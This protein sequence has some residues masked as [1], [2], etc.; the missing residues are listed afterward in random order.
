MIDVYAVHT[1]AKCSWIRRLY[2]NTN[3]KWKITF[4]EMLNIN[5]E[6]LNKNLDKK[7]IEHCRSE[8]HKKTLACWIQLTLNL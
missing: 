4:L 6:I 5:K 2:D 1:T 3:A 8:F 7:M